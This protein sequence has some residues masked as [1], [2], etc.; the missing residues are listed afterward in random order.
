MNAVRAE[1]TK[2]R[3]VRST[4]WMLFA[5]FGV[6]V[7]LSVL[8]T[9]NTHTDGTCASPNGDG[10][11]DVVAISVAGTYLGE[12]IIAALAVLTV[13]SEYT[14]GMIRT[15]FVADPRRRRVLVTRAA[16]VMA[17][18]FVIG[19]I[20]AVTSFLLGR[21]LLTGNGFTA[22]HGYGYTDLLDSTVARAVVGTALFLTLVALLG[23]GVGTIVRH[24]AGAVATV[25]GLL[26][27]PVVAAAVLSQKLG[28]AILKSTPVAGLAIERSARGDFPI[29]PWPGLAVMCGWAL[30]AG[31]IGLVL[32]ARRDA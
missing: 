17:I 8:G 13:T 14:T 9:A 26:L 19:L 27:L 25:L 30:A 7:L 15:T 12:L 4:T 21:P 2:L 20:T 23:L 5:A 22:A 16:V 1:W 10:C 6:S 18:V 28:D 29:S 24:T 3:S 11:R 32:V 31:A